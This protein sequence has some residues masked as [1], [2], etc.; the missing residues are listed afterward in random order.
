MSHQRSL[1]TADLS[2]TEL[3]RNFL[4]DTEGQDPAY[5]QAYDRTTLG[6]NEFQYRHRWVDGLVGG[7]EVLEIPCGVGWGTSI[8]KSAKSI[9]LLVFY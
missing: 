7:L 2:E 5:I 3:Y 1:S 6:Y 8:M 9:V 4:T